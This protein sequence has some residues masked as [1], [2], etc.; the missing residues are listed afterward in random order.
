MTTSWAYLTRGRLVASA[1]SNLGGMML[2]L[3]CIMSIPV[4]AGTVWKG[5]G[6]TDEM[7]RRLTYILVGITLVTL[8]EWG[9]RLITG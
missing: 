5:I 3:L 1:M 8:V 7:V 9:I 2:G 4:L 6:P